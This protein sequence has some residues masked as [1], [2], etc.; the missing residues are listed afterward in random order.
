M[1][2]E[3]AG[4]SGRFRRWRE[5]RRARAARSRGIQGRVNHGRAD[6]EAYAGAGARAPRDPNRR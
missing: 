3:K 4:K 5:R 2:E 1:A 6:F